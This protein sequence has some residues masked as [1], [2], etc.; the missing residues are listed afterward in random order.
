MKNIV[1]SI[2]IL[3]LSSCA[4]MDLIPDKFD[5]V[6]YGALVNLGVIAENSTDCD[7]MKMESA[8]VQSAFLE[9]Y[10]EHTMNDNNHQIYVQIHDLVSE[11]KKRQEPSPAY[12]RIKWG[13]ISTIVEEALAVSGSRMK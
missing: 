7:P 4:V 8:W 5:A 11:L 10:S 6:E 12:C 13:N 9:K 3:L 2:G 1:M